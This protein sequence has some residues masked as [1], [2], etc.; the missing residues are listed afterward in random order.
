MDTILS[1]QQNDT[2]AIQWNHDRPH[3]NPHRH[4]PRITTISDIIYSVQQRPAR[5]TQEKRTARTRLYRRH[6]LRRPKQNGPGKYQ[7]TKATSHQVRTMATKAWRPIRKI[8]I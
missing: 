1:E 5:Y 6:S 7:R 3:T 4:P 8:Q 2:N